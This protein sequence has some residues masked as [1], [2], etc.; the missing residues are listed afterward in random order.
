MNLFASFIGPR[1]PLVFS[2]F[3][4]KFF[5]YLWFL[6]TSSELSNLTSNLFQRPTPSMVN[7]SI[8]SKLRTFFKSLGANV[9]IISL[10]IPAI[11][12][13]ETPKLTV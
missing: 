13:S 1:I 11:S 5:M 12:S 3:S 8:S 4:C 7:S 10:F 6:E 9:S 2:I